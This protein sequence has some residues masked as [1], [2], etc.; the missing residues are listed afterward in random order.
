MNVVAQVFAVVTGLV[1][2]WAFVMESLVFG[3]PRAHRIFLVRTEDVPKI[4][5]WA[6]N[7]GFYNLFFAAGAIG[8]VAILHAGDE[9]V[10][11]T[12]VLFTCA[13]M[14]LAGIVLFVS[15]PR[16]ARLSGALGQGVPPLI[17]LIADRVS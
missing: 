9:T 10:G 5:L 6:F 13:S 15:D 8:G 4:R 12:L 3:Q 16:T 2:L 14:F 11:R 17:V 7:Q 1:H